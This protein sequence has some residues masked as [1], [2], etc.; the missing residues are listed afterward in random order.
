MEDG[1]AL[2]K[3]TQVSR[4]P[5]DGLPMERAV[6]GS[7]NQARN[8]ANRSAAHLEADAHNMT[9]LLWTDDSENSFIHGSV[10]LLNN[11]LHITQSGLYFVYSQATYS[12]EYC[13][14]V[15]P[16]LSHSVILKSVKQ[17]DEVDLLLGVKT[18]NGEKVWKRSIF[19]GAV[20]ELTAGDTLYTNTSGMQCLLRLRGTTYFGLYAL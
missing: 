18:V 8:R 16:L 6:K 5:E 4:D 13:N 2:R 14:N 17:N 15:T 9:N 10:K 1:V 7:R 3:V 12:S 11:E 20:F 19:Q